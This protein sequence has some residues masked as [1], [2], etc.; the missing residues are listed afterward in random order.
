V[1]FNLALST[2]KVNFANYKAI[3]KVMILV[4]RLWSCRTDNWQTDISITTHSSVFIC[5]HLHK[6]YAKQNQ[7]L[8]TNSKCT[9]WKLMAMEPT[10][11]KFT[12]KF[13]CCADR[14]RISRVALPQIQVVCAFRYDDSCSGT[15]YVIQHTSTGP[16]VQQPITAKQ[17]IRHPVELLYFVHVENTML[18]AWFSYMLSCRSC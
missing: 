3:C 2:S 6:A 10:A 14:D 13:T 11:Y 4:F 17:Q 15:W 1:Y 18:T 8:Q 12:V 16:W 5:V 7:P 9:F